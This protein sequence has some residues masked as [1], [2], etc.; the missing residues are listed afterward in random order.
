MICDI[1]LLNREL[2][3]THTSAQTNV[4]LF[5]RV[6]SFSSYSDS[7]SSVPELNVTLVLGVVQHHT[8]PSREGRG[9]GV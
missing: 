6:G 9:T 8:G 3:T 1:K 4:L 5:T 7:S 2:N